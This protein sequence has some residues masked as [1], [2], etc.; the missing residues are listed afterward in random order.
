MEGRQFEMKGKGCQETAK[1]I[2]PVELII[3]IT[4]RFAY[5]S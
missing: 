1:A 2:F 4:I 5:I 3:E